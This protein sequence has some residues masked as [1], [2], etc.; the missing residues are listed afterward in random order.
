MERY[1]MLSNVGTCLLNGNNEQAKKVIR[2]QWAYNMP[3]VEP[4]KSSVPLKTRLEVFRRDNYTCR[5]CGKKTVFLGVLRLLSSLLPNEFPYHDRWRMSKSHPAYW[6]I[7][8]S[9]DHVFPV[10]RGG[11]NDFNNLATTCYKCNSIK[12][13]WSVEE[14]GW[15]LQPPSCEKWDGL[16]SLFIEIITTNVIPLESL[17]NKSSK[18][19]IGDY[20]LLIKI[21]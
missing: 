10:A 16:T 1:Q 15:T 7:T 18:S 11:D 8:A 9:I 5:Y 3:P 12:S 2:E 19:L 4:R 21:M 13:S 17:N 14:L 6:N 20:K